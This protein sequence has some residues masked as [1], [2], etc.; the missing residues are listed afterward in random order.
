[1]FL[2]GNKRLKK[3]SLGILFVISFIFGLEYG[4]VSIYW[5]EL[6]IIKMLRIKGKKVNLVR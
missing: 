2:F 5:F 1:M 3:I 6:I 4:I